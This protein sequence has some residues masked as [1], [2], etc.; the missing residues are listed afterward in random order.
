MKI[1]KQKIKLIGILLAFTVLSACKEQTKET[2][3]ASNNTSKKVTEETHSELKIKP[4]GIING[5]KQVG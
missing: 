1:M 3:S 2:T 4:N 5:V